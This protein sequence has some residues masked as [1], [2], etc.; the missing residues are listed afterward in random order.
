[1][2]NDLRTNFEQANR[3]G[4][5]DI[6]EQVKSEVYPLIKTSNINNK[7]ILDKTKEHL[8]QVVEDNINQRMMM[9]DKQIKNW[10]MT[11]NRLER[12]DSRSPMMPMMG[13]NPSVQPTQN[14]LHPA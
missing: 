2:V 14:S 10:Q 3:K 13:R 9:V 4:Q 7:A 8:L 5:F 1:M 6:L 12:K 11:M